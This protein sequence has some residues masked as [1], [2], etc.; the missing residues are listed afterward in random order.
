MFE[1]NFILVTE[2]EITEFGDLG[3]PAQ[4]ITNVYQIVYIQI[5]ILSFAGN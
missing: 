4:E 1:K 2:D 3:T 5:T